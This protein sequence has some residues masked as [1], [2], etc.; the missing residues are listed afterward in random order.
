MP[1]QLARARDRTPRRRGRDLGHA[2]GQFRPDAT[3]DGRKTKGELQPGRLLVASARLE[4]PDAHAQSG[5]DLPHAVLQHEGRR[6]DRARYSAGGR[7]TVRSPAASTTSGRRRWRMS[8]PPA[9]TRARAASISSCRRA[10]RTSVPEG[11]IALQSATYRS[12]ALL[13]SNLTSGS[14]ADV[15]KAVAYGKRVKVYPLSQAAS[16]PPTVLRRRDRR[17]VRQHHPL[18]PAASS[19]RST[20]SCSASRGSTATG[21]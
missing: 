1:D 21:R 20:A 9:S 7:R 2:G 8:V 15:A 19:S 3:G 17:R 13:R 12:Y 18:R 5:R 11:Y 14:D 6:T 16:P 4:E 10:T